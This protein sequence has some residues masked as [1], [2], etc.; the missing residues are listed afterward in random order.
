MKTSEIMSIDE[1]IVRDYHEILNYAKENDISIY[2]MDLSAKAFNALRINDCL[3]LSQFVLKTKAEIDDICFDNRNVAEEIFVFAR[4]WLY[5]N[6]DIIS[7]VSNAMANSDESE[8]CFALSEPY[9]DAKGAD[10]AVIHMQ[11]LLEK[12]AD[13]V[14]YAKQHDAPIEVLNLS[15]RPYNCLKHCSIN[16]LSKLVE[17]YPDGYTDIRNMGTKSV[18]EINRS[19]ESYFTNIDDRVQGAEAEISDDMQQPENDSAI[20]HIQQALENDVMKADFVQYAKQHDV[21]IEV[22]AL[23]R[24]SS[25]CLR[26]AEIDKLSKLIE[27][28]PDGYADIR[29]M[30][31][32]SVNEINHAIE[33]YLANIGDRIQGAASKI[34]DDTQQGDFDIELLSSLQLFQHE[35]TKDK[36]WEYLYKNDTDIEFMSL[37]NRSTHAL[38]SAGLTKFSSLL[39]IY[40]SGISS[41]RNL[42]AKSDTEIKNAVLSHLKKIRPFVK[43]Y[44]CSG[45]IQ[46]LYSDE[47][48]K[49]TVLNQFENIG[50]AGLSFKEI[51]EKLP[52]DIDEARIKKT[53]GALL[54][55]NIIEY[56]D[57]RC[58]RVY[59]SI[60]DILKRE[61]ELSDDRKTAYLLR[62]YNDETLKS[63]AKSEGLTRERVRQLCDKEYKRIKSKNAA[64][65]GL[66]FF[67]E[68]YYEY[69][70]STYEAPME[71][72]NDF[73]RLP[74]YVFSYLK[75]TYTR[76]KED[77]E[78]ALND[79]KLDVSL[80]IRIRD[81]LNRNKI[82][83]DG[84]LLD[85]NRRDI[86]DFVLAHYC[87]DEI[88]F[89]KFVLLYNEILQKNN[90]NSSDM[91]ITDDVIQTRQNRLSES[92]MCLWKQGGRL[93]YYDIDAGDYTE[94]LENIS[95]DDY[96]D[97]D[98]STLK[99][100]EDYPEVM[101]MY[102][103]RDEYELHNLLRKI[104]GNDLSKDIRFSRQP[105]ISFGQSDRA[106][107]Y[108]RIL[109]AVSP[110][111]IEEFA[112]YIH[113]ENG[114]N[115]QTIMSSPEIQQLSRYYHNGVY[116]VDFRHLPDDQAER[117]KNLLEDD[118]YYIDEI[119]KIYKNNFSN[120][121]LECINPRSLKSI[122]FN[123]F[124]SYAIRNY[125]TAEA[126]FR[127]LLTKDD[128]FDITPYRLK[129]R[130]LYMYINIVMDLRK[131]Y[132]I[133]LFEDN[134][135]I[136]YRR[137]AKAGVT[138][139]MIEDFCYEV[140]SIVPSN[141]YF[142]MQS[143]RN[144]GFSH[145]LDALGFDDI[146]YAGI[147][148]VSPFFSYQRV[149][150]NI[151]LY[152]GDNNKKFSTKTFI[153]SMLE[154]YEDI[155][156]DDFID[157][158][159]EKYGIRISN[160]N[161]YDV[162]AAVAGTEMYYDSIMNKIYSSKALYYADLDD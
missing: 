32:K 121:D 42:G 157:D 45:D 114:F 61:H 140:N 33:R 83:I 66:K 80:K 51:K 137:L 40:P 153:Q 156:I 58:Y 78:G 1:W 98:I 69:F 136:N 88:T 134:Q 56:V 133:F 149:Y 9:D 18:E 24:R 57:F 91:L 131:E 21:P 106:E 162:I 108:Q 96:S 41:L 102:D 77:L 53:I 124:S 128:V 104:I 8:Q 11:Q 67:D 47:Y 92:K 94:L 39:K 12:K 35:K 138:K 151:V 52:E 160:E 4:E 29:N 23:S 17:L 85:K 10:S 84:E 74:A 142:T 72:F 155:D 127:N 62:R 38:L 99:F 90:I 135:Y 159:Y 100:I 79:S 13:Y 158:V 146:F 55:D 44:C 60:M 125:P 101:E 70:Y 110:V 145:E 113:M 107:L 97:I 95:L 115:K 93:R 48:I 148:A 120:A 126:Y 89:D 49:N 19:I 28:Y 111:T 20:I 129:Y 161:K 3:L 152:S 141:I 112:E 103:I 46:T 6:R 14:Q 68:D 139:Q 144:N 109:N 147:L 36:A 117:L 7:S 16:T 27:L 75:N 150:G 82:E 59:P 30:G 81:Y 76:G 87:Q 50:F 25:N 123:V 31:V 132:E 22:L 119:V 2:D 65:N 63:I 122:G 116:S 154:E 34:Y 64:E 118:F 15:K 73:L 37:S 26:R 143:L 86:E 105:V 130:G 54:R 5:T 43:T 71:F